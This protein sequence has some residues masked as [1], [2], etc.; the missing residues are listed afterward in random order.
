MNRK[1]IIVAEV[2][3]FTVSA[4]LGVLWVINP[5]APFEPF[6]LVTSLV[7]AATELY[8][9]YEGHLFKTEG[10]SRTPTELVHHQEILRKK[11]EEEIDRCR[12][13]KLRKDIIIRHVNRLDDYPHTKE[14][15][16]GIS[17]WFRVSLLD[18][19]HKG[20][21]VGLNWGTL[22]EK[23]N[24]LQLTNHNTE[25]TGNIKALLVG[26][27]PYEYI[28]TVNIDG[29]EYYNFPHIYCHFAHNGE[30]YERLI[31]CQEVNMGNGHTHFSEIATYDEVKLNSKG[32]GV[33]YFS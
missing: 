3:A 14:I 6:I 1:L 18:T 24:G 12:R 27:I 8:R 19:Y 32:T 26:E 31:F 9:R 13:E 5:S 21:L 30:P 15:S 10:V 20:I 22:T 11:F 7:F 23:T 28:E 16:K 29:D 33:R 4:I 17:P 25:E 2:F